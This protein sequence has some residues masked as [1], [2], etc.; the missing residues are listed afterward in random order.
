MNEK[1]VAEIRRRFRPE[2]SNITHVR[3]CFVNEKRE[4]VSQFNQSLQLSSQEETES[5]LSVLKRTL[6]GG[7]GKNLIDIAFDTRQVVDSPEHRLLMSVRNSGLED[8]QAVQA[9]FD[10]IIQS[11]SLEGNY[12]ILLTH[13]RYDVPY[14]SKDDQTQADASSEVF[15]Y[16][17]CSICPLKIT[18]PALSY[19]ITEKQFCNCKPQWVVAPPELGFLFP[20]FDDRAAN[21]YGALYYTRSTEQNHQELADAVLHC[22]LPMPAAQQEDTFHTI[23]EDSLGEDCSYEVLQGL[24]DQLCGM[25]EEHKAKKE[26]APLAISKQ[27]VKTVLKACNVPEKSVAAFEQQYDAQFG[28][29]TDLAPGNIIDPRRFQV[30]LPDVSIQLNPQRSDLLQIRIVDGV[31]Y[32]L[33]RADE[34]VEVNGVGI[35]IP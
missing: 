27:E 23:L 20:A 30:Q 5:I 2:K 17:L 10:K 18:K 8:E 24:H 1:E 3:G 19:H 33:I 6:S 7:L 9:L 4:M 28:P 26:Q 21:I 12:V 22:Q 14:R 35:H 15:S 16:I 32:I 25:V 11:L 34:G 29:E 31:K 13:D